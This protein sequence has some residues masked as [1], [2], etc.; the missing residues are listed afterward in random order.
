MLGNR[1]RLDM[2]VKEDKVLLVCK[3]KILNI[4][5]LKNK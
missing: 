5:D 3:L 4:L 2:E 1:R